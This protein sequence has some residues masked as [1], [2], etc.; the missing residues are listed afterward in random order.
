MPDTAPLSLPR[1]RVRV[2]GLVQGVGFRPFVQNLAAAHRLAGWVRNDAEGV[3]LEVEG[4]A[5][6]RFLDALRRE[7]PPLARIDALEVAAL[8]AEGAQGFRIE[9]SEPGGAARTAIGADA[10]TC[11]DCLAELFDPRDRRHRYAF[12]NCTRCGPRFTIAAALPYDRARTSMAPFAM[13]ACC[14]A[15]YADPADRRFHAQPTCCPDCGPRLDMEVAEVAARIARGEVVAIKGLGGFQ[16]V[17]DAR[18]EAAVARL[19][20]RKERGA[21]PFALMVANL[22]SA[23]R[24]AEL[25]EAEARL[26]SGIERPILLLRRHGD[27]ALPDALAPGLAQIGIMLPSAPLHWLLF[28]EAA[29]R[30]SGTAWLDAPQGLALVVTS[31]NPGGEPLVIGNA[32]ARAR[33]H[34]IADAI[35]SHDRDILVRADDPVVRVVAGAPLWLRRGRGVTPRPIRL[36]RDSAPVLALGGDLKNAVCVTRGTEAFL[37]QHVGGL[38]DEAT[39][40]FQSEAIAHL[41]GILQVEPRLVVHDRHPD[42]AATRRAEALGLP[43]LAVQHHHAHAVAVLAEHGVVAPTAALI[44]DGYGMGSDGAAWG[45]ELLAVHGAR[46]DRL[47]HLAPLPLPGGDAAAREPWRMA[48]AALHALGRNAEIASRFPHQGAALARMLA[49]GVAC[50]PTSSA[51]RLFDA[52]A[53]LLGVIARSSYEGEAAMRLEALVQRP[54]AD[55]ALWRV[56]AEGTL[57]LLPLLARLDGMAPRDGAGLFHGTLAA[58]LV[59]WATPQAEARGARIALG[60]GCVANAVLTTL[61]VEGFAARGITALLPREAPPGDGGL[62]LGQA[63]IGA[64]HLAGEDAEPCA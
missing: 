32:E 27:A 43:M 4:A 12:L 31:A 52:A 47:G 62:A 16:L 29:G 49:Q 40:R 58:A 41:L 5:C 20:A 46:F 9:A 18:D 42:G 38:S 3:L 11:A 59:E 54:V 1:Q 64:C 61:L 37:S 15:E 21:K 50:S 8:P 48:A 6:L 34:N 19:R 44:L 36:P 7:A 33:L 13:C 63:W 23:R 30:P 17:C 28:H 14:A 10:A 56:T 60:G 35:V 51:G 2:R 55:P 45:G 24:L 39:R 22:A 25:D 26:L 53:G 57:D